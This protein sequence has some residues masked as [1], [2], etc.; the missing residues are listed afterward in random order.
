M[1]GLHVRYLK[2]SWPFSIEYGTLF[3][4]WIGVMALQNLSVKVILFVIPATKQFCADP[5]IGLVIK[6]GIRRAEYEYSR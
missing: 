2:G 3:I 1:L 5:M 4:R 6:F